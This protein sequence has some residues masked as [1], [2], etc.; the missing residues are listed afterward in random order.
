[1]EKRPPLAPFEIV[2]LKVAGTAPVEAAP[3]AEAD[4]QDALVAEE[5]PGQASPDMEAPAEAAVMILRSKPP[6][7]RNRQPITPWRRPSKRRLPNLRRPA[8]RSSPVDSP[9]SEP[10]AD[11]AAPAM[12]EMVEVWRP[13][14]FDR[15]NAGRRP[16]PGGRDGKP[17]RSGRPPHG[18][19][20]AAAGD[21]AQPSAPGDA[22]P[23]VDG[24]R[25][26]GRRDGGK[27]WRKPGEED[28]PRGERRFDKRPR[29]GAERPRGDRP[30]T[31][32]PAHRSGR[33]AAAR[34]SGPAHGGRTRQGSGS[35]F[36]LRK[37]AAL[38]AR[39]EGAK[40]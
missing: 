30:E 8:P 13:T 22:G 1:M 9:A 3:A 10:P 36:P 5:A 6:N 16:R 37:L 21:A 20:A 18:R 39:L 11:A 34:A 7:W 23:R 2:P 35:R 25:G 19:P 32:R 27:P 28:K 33:I 38:K 17:Q 40:E 31:R 14:R 4:A 15:E 26:G 24:Q 29:D 12:P